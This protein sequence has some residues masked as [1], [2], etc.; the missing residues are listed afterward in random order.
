[1]SP[2]LVVFFSSRRKVIFG[3]MKRKIHPGLGFFFSDL[4][5]VLDS[6]VSELDLNA[7]VDFSFQP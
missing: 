7:R 1:M 6:R 4:V 5:S 2:C 3:I